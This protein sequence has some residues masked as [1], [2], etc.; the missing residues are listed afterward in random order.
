[1]SRA[2]VAVLLIL[3]ISAADAAAQE[4]A[5]PEKAIPALVAMLKWIR[6]QWPA[7]NVVQLSPSVQLPPHRD[8][9]DVEHDADVFAELLEGSGLPAGPQP[10]VAPRTCIPDPYPNDPPRPDCRFRDAAAIIVAPMPDLIGDTVVVKIAI[11][12]NPSRPGSGFISRVLRFRAVPHEGGWRV[13]APQL[14]GPIT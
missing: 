1:M 5:P 3:L 4:P 11:W 13:L 12:Q 7:G 2:I 8:S 14:T 9:I 6:A 10:R